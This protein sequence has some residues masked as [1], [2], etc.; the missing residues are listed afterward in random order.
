MPKRPVQLF[1]EADPETNGA[2]KEEWNMSYKGNKVTVAQRS[3]VGS[4]ASW[5]E[6]QMRNTRGERRC[7]LCP[8]WDQLTEGDLRDGAEV[9]T[10]QN[11]GA[12]KLEE[13]RSPEDPKA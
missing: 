12:E 5:R 13:T 6:R 11:G 7:G 8:L 4:D 2:A 10:Q 1:A 9:T 3:E